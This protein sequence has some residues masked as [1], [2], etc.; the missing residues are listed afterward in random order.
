MYKIS[1]TDAIVETLDFFTPNVTDPY[2]FG[3]IAATNS[4]SDVYAMNA[5]PITARSIFTFPKD[6]ETE[7]IAA[8]VKG[9]SDVLKEA[10]CALSGGHTIYDRS[11]KYG[12]SVTGTAKIDSVWR[13]NTP[14]EGDVLLLTKPLGS[15]IV[16]SAMDEGIANK[17]SVDASVKVMTTL[18]MYSASKLSKYDVSAATDITGFG[19]LGHL[20]EMVS[21]SKATAVINPENIGLISGVPELVFEKGLKTKPGAKTKEHIGK[22]VTFE[23]NEKYEEILYDSQTSGGLLLAVNKDQVEK[24]KEDFKND[25]L[26]LFV[27]GEITNTGQTE[28]IVK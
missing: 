14:R 27:I 19:L 11:I 2:L 18:N 22:Y 13:N 6:T 4:L 23:N 28:I 25:N 17:E 9:A 24:I 1:E 26:D 10:K 5:T 8:I 20:Y 3:K 12:L 16:A 7:V 15:G 21:C